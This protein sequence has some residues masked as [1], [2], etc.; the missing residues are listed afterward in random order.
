LN[1]GALP[2]AFELGN[3]SNVSASLGADQ[4]R[5]GLIAGAIG[6]A[7]VLVYCF[8]YYRGLGL[9]VV[10]SL[11][12]AGIAAYLLIVLLGESIGFAL[13][14]PGM[15]GIIVAIGITADSFVIFF[16]RVRDEAREGRGLRTAVETGWH[17]ARRTI[18]VADVVSLLSA[19][20]LY[21]LSIGAVQGFAFALGLTTAIDLAIIFFCTKPLVS[22]L[23]RTEF[24]GQGKPGSGLEAEHL[25][26][27]ANRRPRP[28][29]RLSNA[30]KE[31]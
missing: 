11:A 3:V 28:R 9:A 10:A 18:I 12:V 31:A 6:L 29:R 25:G 19:V 7:L 5:A 26:V 14:L 17:K 15:A 22:L 16:E 23:V 20:I 13:S 30:G 27:S 24:F 21:I 2:L 4:L 1:Y 8:L